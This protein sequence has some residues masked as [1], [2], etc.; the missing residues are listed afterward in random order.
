MAVLP[1]AP[2][3]LPPGLLRV[4]SLHA[5]LP[6]VSPRT[7]NS[8]LGGVLLQEMFE[9]VSI[10]EIFG[11]FFKTFFS[12]CSSDS[13]FRPSKRLHRAVVHRRWTG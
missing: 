3:P 11:C 8:G 10:D 9:R 12:Y 1:A 4:V 6:E 2:F 7:G 13:V 5:Q